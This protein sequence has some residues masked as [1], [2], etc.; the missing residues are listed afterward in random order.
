MPRPDTLLAMPAPRDLGLGTATT[1]SQDDEIDWKELR[2]RM[3]SLGVVGYQAREA[4][5]GGWVFACQLKTSDPSRR[6]RIETP[7][8]ATEAQ[9]ISLAL[10]EAERWV[11]ANR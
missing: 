9:A 6:H 11:A 1:P 5:G 2:H 3:Q 8:A 4:T 7:P 10:A